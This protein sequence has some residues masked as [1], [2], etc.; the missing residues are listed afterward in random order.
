MGRGDSRKTPKVRQ[1]KAWRKAKARLA[2][3]IAGAGKRP[4]APKAARPAG[5]TVTKKKATKE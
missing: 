5:S 4:S 3:K 2:A 1:R